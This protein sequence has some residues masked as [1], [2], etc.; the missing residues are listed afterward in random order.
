MSFVP[1]VCAALLL[2]CGPGQAQLAHGSLLVFRP[3]ANAPLRVIDMRTG[4]TRWRLPPGVLAGHLVVHRD[5]RLLTWFDAATGARVGD[6]VLQAHGTFALVGASQDGRTAVLARTQTHSTTF[7]L[8]TVQHEREVSRPGHWRFEAL[9]GERLT[10]VRAQQRRFGTPVSTIDSSAGRY[11]LTLYR[12]G[13]AEAVE[14]LDTR[15]GRS[16][17]LALGGLGYTLLPDPEEHQVWAVSLTAGRV[18]LLDAAS[19]A[20]VSS[21]QFPARARASDTV[22]ALAP[23]GEHIAASDGD[24][25][26]VLTPVRHVTVRRLRPHVAIALGFSPDERTLWVVGQRSRVSPLRPGLVH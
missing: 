2:A 21:Y 15:T 20:T 5:A 12:R 25:V 7:A 11:R 18:A 24:H 19:G 6:A 9:N 17:I 13:L 3:Q 8:V 4:A 22:A 26:F 10:L 14:A 16:R 1:A 23:D